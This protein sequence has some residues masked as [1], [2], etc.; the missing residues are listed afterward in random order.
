MLAPREAFVVWLLSVPLF[1]VVLVPVW[2]DNCD[3]CDQP[4]V[5][6]WL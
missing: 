2:R 3:N 4:L 5:T 1:T 6:L